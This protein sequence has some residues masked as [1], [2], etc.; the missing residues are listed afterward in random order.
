MRGFSNDVGRQTAPRLRLFLPESHPSNAQ[1]NQ[2]S[3]I[4]QQCVL[5][6]LDIQLPAYLAPSQLDGASAIP[7]SPELGPQITDNDHREYHI[8]QANHQDDRHH[9]P[10]FPTWPEQTLLPISEQEAFV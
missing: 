7:I 3:L 5:T 8:Q 10:L 6:V 4:I 2:E 9:C 1:K